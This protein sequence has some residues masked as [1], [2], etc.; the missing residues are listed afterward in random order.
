MMNYY[1]PLPSEPD[2]SPFTEREACKILLNYAQQYYEILACNYSNRMYREVHKE[3]AVYTQAWL[4][5]GLGLMRDSDGYFYSIFHKAELTYNSIMDTADEWWDVFD[6]LRKSSSHSV[7]NLFATKMKSFMW[8]TIYA[9]A[10][11]QE[12]LLSVKVDIL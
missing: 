12:R 8:S 5:R 6:D 3:N 9:E 10:D 4:D 11:H 7:F 2:L 1:Y